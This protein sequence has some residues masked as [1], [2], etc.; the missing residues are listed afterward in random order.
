MCSQHHFFLLLIASPFRAKTTHE[1]RGTPAC[2]GREPPYI[3]IPTATA[4]RR[5]E[6]HELRQTPMYFGKRVPLPLLPCTGT[7]DRTRAFAGP[8]IYSLPL[9]QQLPLTLGLFG[10]QE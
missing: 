5:R 6:K 4:F 2:F 8:P 7:D 10:K 9:G 1:N 3:H